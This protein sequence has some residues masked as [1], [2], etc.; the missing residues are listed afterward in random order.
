MIRNAFLSVVVIAIISFSAIKA[1][2]ITGYWYLS[3]LSEQINDSNPLQL[4]YGETADLIYCIESD[5]MI[6]LSQY[7]LGF[8]GDATVLLDD[9]TNVLT[10]PGATVVSE[11]IP[12]DTAYATLSNPA[13]VFPNTLTPLGFVSM[14][15]DR[16]GTF[17]LGIAGG[18]IGS[19]ELY[20]DNSSTAVIQVGPDI[21]G[22]GGSYA[23]SLEPYTATA[24]ANYDSDSGT[25]IDYVHVDCLLPCNDF[26]TSEPSYASASVS[27]SVVSN[28]S[29]IT[30][31]L[32]GDAGLDVWLSNPEDPES[33]PIEEPIDANASGTW[34]GM[35]YFDSADLGLADGTLLDVT[36]SALATDFESG[37]WSDWECTFY[38]D[39]T[40]LVVLDSQNSEAVVQVTVG[41]TGLRL[42]VDANNSA[43]FWMDETFDC[44]LTVGISGSQSTVPEPT[45]PMMILG[46]SLALLGFR[47]R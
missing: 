44:Q 42:R 40:E 3:D 14:T 36:F 30:I 47:R 10:S 1:H 45:L 11:F 19:I 9:W 2:A 26:V 35:I 22:P 34:D 27:T 17:D 12:P 29:I 7:D 28:A 23:P 13:L 18:Q 46:S 39:S 33:M 41:E 37:S 21:P 4:E 5:S 38:R 25:N 31:G 32:Q 8:S 24:E 43:N 16:S 20:P 15:G 6:M